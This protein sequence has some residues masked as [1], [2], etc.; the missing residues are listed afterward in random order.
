MHLDQ[1][2]N[3]GQVVLGSG[4]KD[5][6][7]LDNQ[8]RGIIDLGTE[9]IVGKLSNGGYLRSD[10]TKGFNINGDFA[11][12]LGTVIASSETIWQMSADSDGGKQLSRSVFLAPHLIINHDRFTNNHK[13]I[14]NAPVTINSKIFTNYGEISSQDLNINAESIITA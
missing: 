1:L 8:P 6:E 10:A 14:F 4:T 12:G 2:T 7:Y 3:R 13:L 9:T 5:I 11:E